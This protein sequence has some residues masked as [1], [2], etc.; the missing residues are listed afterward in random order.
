LW[1]TGIPDRLLQV[2]SGVPS[3][4]GRPKWRVTVGPGRQL[5]QLDIKPSE[6]RYIGL[7]N[8]HIDH[9]GN[10]A[11]FPGA[12]VLIQ[13]SELVYEQNRQVGEKAE[14]VEEAHIEAGPSTMTLDGDHD[15]FGDGTAVIIA[16]RSVSPGNQSLLVKPP[17][18]GAIVLSG[19]LIHF[20]YG[21]DNRIV[22]GNVWNKE[23][24]VES[25]VRLT[26]IIKHYNAQLWI[27]HDKSKSN[28]RKFSPDY[29]E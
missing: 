9:I 22:P 19:D 12:S 3:Y 20:Q 6:I 13:K 4:D 25:F 18:S 21:W 7:A 27:E 23:K 14:R 29:Y 1:G 28:S 26:D 24:T 16:T 10:L 2:P 15:V 5:A 17:K 11:M 8:A